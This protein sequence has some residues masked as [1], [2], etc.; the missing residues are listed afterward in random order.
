MTPDA[1]AAIEHRLAF[2]PRRHQFL[3]VLGGS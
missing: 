2:D 3:G 1:L